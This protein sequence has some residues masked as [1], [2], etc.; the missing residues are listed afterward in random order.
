MQLNVREAAKFLDVSE[1]TL[2]RWA[3]DGQIPL[4]RVNGQYR[5]SRTE[6]VEW[7]NARKMKISTEAFKKDEATAV[8]RVSA[9]LEVG[10]VV[11]KLGGADKPSVLKALVDGLKLPDR[12]DRSMLYEILVAREQAGTTAMGG[13]IAIPHVR[14]PM[15]LPVGSP[16]ITLFFLEKPV[17]F[18]APDGQPVHALFWLVSPTPAAHLQIVSRLA[19]LLRDPGFQAVVAKQRTAEEVLREARRAEGKP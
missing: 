6:L 12:V 15:V 2:Y 10:G 14:H 19:S 11:H 7:A 3:N 4:Y 16:A 17:D 1:K 5:F 8:P 18:G 13:G 9:A